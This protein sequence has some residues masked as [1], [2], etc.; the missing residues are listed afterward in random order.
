MTQVSSRSSNHYCPVHRARRIAVPPDGDQSSN[1]LKLLRIQ[2]RICAIL[3]ISAS[4]ISS[5]RPLLLGR[6]T[7]LPRRDTAEPYSG[8]LSGP[9]AENHH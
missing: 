3:L 7:P 1:S 5:G 6:V 8:I 9:L 2:K 4:R